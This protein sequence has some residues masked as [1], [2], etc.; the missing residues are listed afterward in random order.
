MNFYTVNTIY[1]AFMG[2]VNCHG[3][4]VRCTFIRLAGCNLRCY[5]K[6][7][8]ILCDTPEAL[9]MCSGRRME[10]QDIF[11]EVQAL[12]NKVVCITGGEPLLH[13][14]HSLLGI[15]S[16]AGYSIV[17]ETNGSKN[18]SPYR[19]IPNVS[20][21]VDVKSESSGE[22]H[23]MIDSHYDIFTDKDY[24]KFVI[25][26][27][28]DYKEMYTWICEHPLFRGNIAAGLF[29]GSQMDY[30]E[31]MRLIIKDRLSVHL[32]MQTHK[33]ACLYDSVKDKVEL[34]DIIIPK[35]L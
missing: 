3:I 24:V 26:T 14:L 21:V 18:I 13:D 30:Q 25:D 5:K 12:Q 11:R 1:P 23:R 32:N 6:T 28:Q 19:H 22:S 2:E 31:L 27:M 20:F 33:M 17:I 34:S 29:W 9:D 10:S 15:L 4:G 7:K 8:G 35:E 16:G